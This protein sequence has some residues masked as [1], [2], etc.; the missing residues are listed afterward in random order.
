MAIR[1]N[2]SIEVK[3]VY[4]F[5]P[6]PTENEVFK[7]NWVDQVSHDIPFSDGVTGEIEF[8]ITAKTPIFIRN[9]HSKDIADKAKEILKKEKAQRNEEEKEILDNYL[10]FSHIKKKNGDKE[11]FIP[12]T[13]VK[14]MTRNMVEIITNSRMKQVNDHHHSVRQIIKNKVVDEGYELTGK[15][16]KR[17]CAGW[18]IEQNNEYYIYDCGEPLKIRYTEIDEHFKNNKEYTT[19]FEEQFGKTLKSKINKD[20]S[21]KTARYKYENVLINLPKEHAFELHPRE[22]EEQQSWVSKFQHLEYVQFVKNTKGDFV[23]NIIC[24]GQASGYEHNKT[25]RKGEYVFKGAKSQILQSGNKIKVDSEIMNTFLFINRNNLHDELDD[26]GYWKSKLETG[27]P[28]FFRKKLEEKIE[29]GKKIRYRSIIDFG[30]TFMY[31]QPV[32]SSIKE[33]YPI[34]TYPKEIDDNYQ[35]DWAETI[36]GFAYPQKKLKGRVYFSHAFLKGAPKILPEKELVL[37]SPRS[38]YFPFYMSQT[39]KGNGR[40][41][42]YFTYNH[43]PNLAGF[44]KYPVRNNLLS[45]DFSNFKNEIKTKIRPLDQNTIF[46]G[47]FRYHNLRKAE[48]GALI[49]A[50][51]FHGKEDS[52]SHNIGAAKPFGYGKIEIKLNISETQKRDYL[53]SFEYQMIKEKSNWHQSD[54]VKE[55]LAMSLNPQGKVIST[56][57]YLELSDFQKIK[58]EGYFL[59]PYSKVSNFKGNFD[60]VL[61]ESDIKDNKK[62]EEDEELARQAQEVAKLKEL[63]LNH[64]KKAKKENSPDT[65]NE[66]LIHYPNSEYRNEIEEL[67]TI[68]KQQSNLAAIQIAQKEVFLPKSKSFNELKKW[69]NNL[70]KLKGFYFS[71]SQTTQIKNAIIK[72]YKFENENI[73]KSNFYKKKNLALFHQFPWTDIKKW[74]GQDDAF[75]LYKEITG[76]EA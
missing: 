7:P 3:S 62:K 51:T 65:L 72:S 71:A 10:S 53:K 47:S 70:L 26:W 63:E 6:A 16:K 27:I 55:L 25:A 58:N 8:T 61:S 13:S 24:V 14:G 45:K 32:K 20:F 49:S 12:S 37:S 5:A 19:S 39:D 36:F 75:D 76:K 30:L 18:L 34:K 50:L 11:Y 66:F 2:Q 35:P 38:S 73:K 54:T 9:G 60:S 22:T 23:G 1:N 48:I 59:K 31:K 57:D 28:V 42:E 4:N 33:S 15:E 29:N 44:K 67:L 21:A 68:H 43:F 64:F 46:H 17:I 69:A 41:N 56:L 40:T 52:Y 74:L